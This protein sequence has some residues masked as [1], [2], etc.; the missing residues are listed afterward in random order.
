MKIW[1]RFF[2]FFF[3][4]VARDVRK[5]LFDKL[6]IICV[7]VSLMMFYLSLLMPWFL[8]WPLYFTA[9]AREH[10]VCAK[11]SCRVDQIV[12]RYG[13]YVME[14][15]WISITF[16]L[17]GELLAFMYSTWIC[18]IMDKDLHRNQKTIV[19]C[20]VIYLRWVFEHFWCLSETFQKWRLNRKNLRRY[21]FSNLF[22]NFLLLWSTMHFI[23]I[24]WNFLFAL[25]GFR[26]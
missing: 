19:I 5:G 22:Q 7:L 8:E 16:Q 14:M 18:V 21:A 26:P 17:D 25:S 12:G 1:F 23:W 10:K 3:A 13:N 2:S 24:V 6:T 15:S 11:C 20:E 4:C 9:C